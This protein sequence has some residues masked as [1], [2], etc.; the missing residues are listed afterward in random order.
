M[1]VLLLEKEEFPR[2][3][4]CGDAISGK[5]ISVLRELGLDGAVEQAPHSRAMGVTFSAPNGHEVSIPFPKKVDPDSMSDPDKEHQYITPGYCCRREV[6]DNIVFQAAKKRDKVEVVENFTVSDVVRDDDGIVRGVTGRNG[7]GSEKEFRAQAVVGA[8][9][10]LDPVSRS[11]G[12]YERDPYHWIGAFRIYYDNV[13]GLTEDI[14]LHFVDDLIP[15]YFWIFPVG[16]GRANVGAGMLEAYLK[17]VDGHE[18]VNMKEITFDII[19]NHPKFKDRFE[20]AE[21]VEDSFSGWQLPVGSDRRKM[22][23][24][25]WALVGDAASLIDPFSG[26]GI[27]NALVSAKK[28]SEVLPDAIREGDVTE[29]NLA[30]YEQKVSDELDRELQLS[31]KLQQ[32]GQMDFMGWRPLNYVIK[33]ASKSE[34]V[35]ELISDMLADRDKKESFGSFWFYLKLLFK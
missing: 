8:G 29:E 5:S 6:F 16:D 12:A 24:D 33:R 25:G 14:E 2:D 1:D 17:G 15:G 20:N 19:E 4:P 3:K 21:K 11:V 23:G 22:H 10:A 31:Y 13:E 27:G 32:I 18:K 28:L 26:E 34:E 7:D 35:Q 30:P 9:G